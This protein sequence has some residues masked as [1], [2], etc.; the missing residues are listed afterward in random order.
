MDGYEKGTLCSLR[1]SVTLWATNDLNKDD[2][3]GCLGFGDVFIPMLFLP[4]QGLIQ[5]VSRLGVGWIN[6]GTRAC[7]LK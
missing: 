7:E 6:L 3:V 1:D 2:Q 5:V 4:K